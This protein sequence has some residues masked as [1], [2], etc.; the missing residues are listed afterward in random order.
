[1]NISTLL[2]IIICS[3]CGVISLVLLTYGFIRW[4]VTRYKRYKRFGFHTLTSKQCVNTLK[5]KARNFVTYGYLPSVFE[6][7]YNSLNI[8]S[9]VKQ[10]KY[11]NKL[12]KKYK[13]KRGYYKKNVNEDNRLRILLTAQYC[14][15]FKI[16]L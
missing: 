5:T 16:I 12:A 10:A 13:K 3:V 15:E 2:T 8:D 7:L 14:K 11:L 1:M 9:S 6:S 4:L